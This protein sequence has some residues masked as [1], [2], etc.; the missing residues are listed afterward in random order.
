MRISDIDWDA[1]W[2][3]GALLVTSALTYLKANETGGKRWEGVRDVA[4]L[5]W[6]S[7]EMRKLNPDDTV[8][9]DNTTAEQAFIDQMLAM[10]AKKRDEGKLREW[11]RVRSKAD[12]LDKLANGV[13]HSQG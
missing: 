6:K 11:A 12:K 10:G 4:E 13:K 5:V 9:N 3:I 1:A 7:V 2:K 8:V